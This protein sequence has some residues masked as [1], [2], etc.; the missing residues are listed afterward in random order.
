MKRSSLGN[1]KFSVSVC[2]GSVILNLIQGLKR[3]Q[4]KGFSKIN[5]VLGFNKIAARNKLNRL[6]TPASTK[7]SSV[8]NINWRRGHC[9]SSL[10][11]FRARLKWSNQ[12]LLWNSD[13]FVSPSQVAEI[14]NQISGLPNRSPVVYG[15]S[16]GRELDLQ[17]LKVLQGS[18]MDWHL[19][20]RDFNKYL[21]G[22]IV[23]DR[24]S[25]HILGRRLAVAGA[26]KK[27]CFTLLKDFL[28]AGGCLFRELPHSQVQ[29]LDTPT[30]LSVARRKRM[31]WR[32]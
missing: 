12:L 22:P 3:S 20:D 28:V 27:P 5:F 1:N 23:L 30:D 21:T 16:T 8:S 2:S 14:L 32:T 4:L 13:L 19:E 9:S 26:D 17:R 7:V 11:R 18:V 29:E 15:V 10:V 31:R 25:L 6:S 24:K